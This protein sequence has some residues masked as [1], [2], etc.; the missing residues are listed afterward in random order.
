M[1]IIAALVYLL[2]DTE[3]G[4]ILMRRALDNSF[5]AL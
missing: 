5:M 4:K 3:Q 1:C 2:M